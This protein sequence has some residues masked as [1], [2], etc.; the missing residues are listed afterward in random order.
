MVIIRLMGGLGNQMF[1][2]ALMKRFESLGVDSYLDLSWFS[3]NN[4][5]NGI[6]L[7]RAF[8]I[9]VSKKIAKEYECKKL[10]YTTY[11]LLHKI[12]HRW[13]GKRTYIEQ[14]G[15]EAIIYD[16]TILQRDNI[17][18]SGY[19]QSYK[20]F[21]CI[22]N[23]LKKD[24]EFKIDIID[25][26][27]IKNIKGGESVSLHIRRGDYIGNKLHDG[28]CNKEY[29]RNAINY[30]NNKLEKPYFYIFSDD[31]EWCR[32]NLIDLF[33]NNY[34]LVD[35]Y[36][37]DRSYADMYL[38]SICKHHIIANSSF[39]WWGAYLNYDSES[40]TLCP[41]RWLNDNIKIEDI[42]L[43]NWEIIA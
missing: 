42:I 15:S 16:N 38:M 41:N 3:Q 9:D 28:I 14:H 20:Y 26:N 17:Y 27:L 13:L 39:S 21:D 40:I 23:V 35:F 22:K 34:L 37:G 5:H 11:D 6:E 12:C 2:Y 31:K 43:F 18:L 10:G 36:D 8:G 30:I 1:Q 24:F 29:Y 4:A 33:M 19:W 32:E 7:N 25:D